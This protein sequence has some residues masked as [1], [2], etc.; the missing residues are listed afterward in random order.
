MMR[1]QILRMSLRLGVRGLARPGFLAALAGLLGLLAALGGASDLGILT[2][3]RQ[4]LALVYEVAFIGGLLGCLLGLHRADEWAWAAS[5]WEPHEV[6]CHETALMALP[7][8]GLAA[9]PLVWSCCAGTPAAPL[10]AAGT[11]AC[12][13]RPIAVGLVARR[14]PLSPEG[15]ALVLLALCWWIP[16]I[17]APSLPSSLGSL[18]HLAAERGDGAVLATP[19]PWVAETSLLAALLG[20]AWLGSGRTPRRT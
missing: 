11:L 8:L 9:P 13:A 17:L 5:R 1:A 4:D 14:L 16:A 2:F 3:D 6:L 15:R 20:A 19:A 18:V 10:I 12:L 7:A